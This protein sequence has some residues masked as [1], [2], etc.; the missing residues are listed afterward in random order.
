MALC[1]GS[2]SAQA[3][4]KLKLETTSLKTP[5][6]VKDCILTSVFKPKDMN[7]IEIGDTYELM[8]VIQPSRIVGH[9]IQIAPSQGG[10]TIRYSNIVVVKDKYVPRVEACL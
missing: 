5:R 10:S 4:P 8:H 7:V 1:L 2:T 6:E 3:D 9:R